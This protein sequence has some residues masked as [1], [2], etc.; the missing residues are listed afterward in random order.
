M[1]VG[2]ILATLTQRKRLPGEER[3]A[4]TNVYEMTAYEPHSLDETLG[5]L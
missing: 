5:F 1:A 4:R 2:S 3:E